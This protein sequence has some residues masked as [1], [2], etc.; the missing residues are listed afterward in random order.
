VKKIALA[1]SL[2]ISLTAAVRSQERPPQLLVR[3]SQ[4]LVAKKFLL[5]AKTSHFTLGYL[6]DEKSY[7]GDKMLYVVNYA[8]PAKANGLVFVVFVTEHDGREEFDIQNN[9]SFVL[10]R[11]ESSGVSFLSP[12]LGGKWTQQHLASAI[13]QIE[14]QPRFTILLKDLSSVGAGVTCESYSDPER[15]RGEKQQRVP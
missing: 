13:K 1:I 6:L 11:E 7:P 4:C 5:P 3:A 2:L 9:A 10:S 12:P 15:K 14:N 8:A